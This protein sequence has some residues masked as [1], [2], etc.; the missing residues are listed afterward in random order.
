MYNVI[1]NTNIWNQWIIE[2]D[3]LPIEQE[4]NALIAALQKE[5]DLVP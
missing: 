2:K 1:V 5:Y 3:L 4:G